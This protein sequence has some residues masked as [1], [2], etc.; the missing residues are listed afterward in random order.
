M[1]CTELHLGKA[2]SGHAAEEAAGP[3]AFCRVCCLQNLVTWSAVQLRTPQC[4]AARYT[5]SAHACCS[6]GWFSKVFDCSYLCAAEPPILHR[7]SYFLLLDLLSDA[8]WLL[9]DCSHLSA[10][11]VHTLLRAS[12]C[13][14]LDCHSCAKDRRILHDSKAADGCC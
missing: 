9:F 4:T 5:A 3:E 12:C 2:C 10:A 8:A 7:A 6:Y 14:L 13:F 1:A 11:G